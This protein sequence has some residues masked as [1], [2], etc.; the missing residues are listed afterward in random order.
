MRKKYFFNSSFLNFFG[1]WAKNFS[2]FRPKNF[3]NLL[4]LPSTCPEEQ[5]V[6][7]NFF[8]KFWI[9]LDFLKKPLAWFSKFYIR[10]QSKNCGKNS[11]FVFLSTNFSNF[12]QNFFTPLAKKVQKFVKTNFCVSTGTTCDFNFFKKKFEPFWIF[13]RSLWHVSQDSI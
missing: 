8:L 12:E 4:K 3:K 10:V 6:A 1:F 9:V 13:Y 2:D 5:F 11:F 7:R